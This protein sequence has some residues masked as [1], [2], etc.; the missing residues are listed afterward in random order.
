M[1]DCPSA[2]ILDVLAG[3]LKGPGEEDLCEHVEGCRSCQEE[4]ERLVE[5]TAPATLPRGRRTR[6]CLSS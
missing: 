4:L 2:T 5:G 3:M 1:L 6:A